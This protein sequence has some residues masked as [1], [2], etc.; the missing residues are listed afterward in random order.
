MA[1][2]TFISLRSDYFTN[3]SYR[4]ENSLTK[5]HAFVEAC[6]GMLAFAKRRHHDGTEQEFDFSNLQ[7]QLERAE[8][9]IEAHPDSQTGGG[10]VYPDFS[11][12]RG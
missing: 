3:L 6:I 1:D 12:L 2:P 7:S 5:A 4:R 8:H 11:N 9:W 10:V